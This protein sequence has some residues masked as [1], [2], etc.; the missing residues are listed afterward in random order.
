M[1]ENREEVRAGSPNDLVTLEAVR[2]GKAYYQ[3]DTSNTINEGVKV[4]QNALHM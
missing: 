2:D 1:E 3:Y 4:V